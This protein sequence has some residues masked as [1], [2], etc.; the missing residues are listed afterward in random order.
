MLHPLIEPKPTSSRAADKPLSYHLILARL[1]AGNKL[2]YFA[3]RT[4]GYATK[5]WCSKGD[6][7]SKTNSLYVYKLWI[8]VAVAFLLLLPDDVHGWLAQLVVLELCLWLMKI[9]LLFNVLLACALHL[10]MVIFFSNACCQ[11]KFTQKK[12]RLRIT[13][14]RT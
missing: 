9:D 2:A 3:A 12:I 4:V 1:R 5:L 14:S 8:S 10:F 13:N 11:L 7:G 6:W